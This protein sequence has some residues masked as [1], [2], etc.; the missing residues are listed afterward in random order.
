MFIGSTSA[1][2]E[3]ILALSL[4]IPVAASSMVKFIGR[5]RPLALA[6]LLAF[7]RSNFLSSFSLPESSEGQETIIILG[8][9]WPLGF[10][11]LLIREP[12]SYLQPPFL[13]Y[14][15]G[16]NHSF[17]INFHSLDKQ[18]WKSR[19][20]VIISPV[21]IQKISHMGCRLFLFSQVVYFPV[22]HF[23]V[24]IIN[25]IIPWKPDHGFGIYCF[26]KLAL[27]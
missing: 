10:L 16:M 6:M 25:K 8:T 20:Q 2:L 22:K 12:N 14:Y 26:G 21:K 23:C 11:V 9:N 27:K 7:L 17:C 3:P 13:F 1:K 24:Y 15:L 18:L 5:Q 4:S 19:K